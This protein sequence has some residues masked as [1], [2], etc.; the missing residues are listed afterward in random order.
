MSLSSL[1]SSS[2]FGKDCRC[3]SHH[4]ARLNGGWGSKSTIDAGRGS[5]WSCRYGGAAWP[6]ES[7]DICHMSY[8]ISLAANP[9]S[10]PPSPPKGA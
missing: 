7:Y 5:A 8:P 6:D 4:H 1:T 9:I 10:S 3:P 2:F